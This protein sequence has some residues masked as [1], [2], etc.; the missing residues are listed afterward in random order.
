MKS[1]TPATKPIDA[2]SWRTPSP[3]ASS[4]SLWLADD[5]GVVAPVLLTRASCLRAVRAGNPRTQVF[6]FARR[7]RNVR[8]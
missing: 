7:L 2:A 1:S 3:R 6:H 4:A 5:N 8:A